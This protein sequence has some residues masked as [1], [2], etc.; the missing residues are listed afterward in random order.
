MKFADALKEASRADLPLFCYEGDGTRALIEIF[1]EHPTQKSVSLMIG[2]EGG[3]SPEEASLAKNEG[4]CMARLGNR[5]LR[6]ETAPLY[7][8]ASLS[9]VYEGAFA[10]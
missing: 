8:L 7:V 6:T 3:Y 4:M 5:I 9:C 2:P 10:E 1:G